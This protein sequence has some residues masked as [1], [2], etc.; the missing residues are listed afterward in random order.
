MKLLPKVTLST[1]AV[2]TELD[3]AKQ[4]RPRGQI[5]FLFPEEAERIATC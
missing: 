2:L 1:G 5:R 3:E 4:L